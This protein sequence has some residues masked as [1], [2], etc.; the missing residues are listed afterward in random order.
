MKSLKNYLE[1]EGELI[2]LF[3]RLRP[4]INKRMKG[5]M[6]RWGSNKTDLIEALIEREFDQLPVSSKSKGKAI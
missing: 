4:S 1:D 3:V 2:P 5:L 6:K